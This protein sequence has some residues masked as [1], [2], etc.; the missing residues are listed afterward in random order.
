MILHVNRQSI[1]PGPAVHTIIAE[2]LPRAFE[3]EGFRELSRD[4][5][6]PHRNELVYGSQGP[7]PFF[8]NLNDMVQMS[9][10]RAVIV[11][12]NFKRQLSYALYKLRSP[13]ISVK[14][15]LQSLGNEVVLTAAEHSDLIDEIKNLLI[16]VRELGAI[17]RPLLEGFMAK[18]V[19]DKADPFALFVDPNQT[20]GKV[21]D[22][23]SDEWLLDH[24]QWWWFDTLHARRT[25]DFVT[26]LLDIARGEATGGDSETAQREQL[27]SYAIGYLS[28]MASDVVGHAY[29]NSIVG[30]PYRLNQAQRHTVQEKIMDIWAYDYY[31]DNADLPLDLKRLTEESQQAPHLPDR[32]YLDP[33]LIESGM[34]NNFLFTGGRLEPIQWEPDPELLF[35]MQPEKPITNSLRLPREISDNFAEAIGRVYDPDIFGEF[36]AAEAD[37]SYRY[38][39]RFIESA[40]SIFGPV[41]PSELPGDVI[42]SE[43][44]H[45][46]WDEFAEAA[47]DVVDAV[48]PDE[49]ATERTGSSSDCFR[50]EDLAEF[51]QN[52]LDC[53]G[54]AA[55]S[56]VNFFS[57]LFKSLVS[58]IRQAWEIV[59]TLFVTI[60]DEGISITV[61]IVNYGIAQA[62]ERLW[63]AHRTLLL[64]VTSIGFSYMYKDQLHQSQL[65]HFYDPTIPD[66]IGNTPRDLIV[67]PGT[68]T[69]GFPRYGL[70]M[71]PRFDTQVSD[72]LQGLESEGHL[73]VPDTE[74]EDPYTIPGPDIYGSA[75]PEVFISDPHAEMAAA[76][77]GDDPPLSEWIP[78]PEAH[79]QNPSPGG[80]RIRL[81]DFRASPDARG[82]YAKPVLGNAVDLTV[83]LFKQYLQYGNVPNL[84][85]SGDRAIGFPNWAS[86]NGCGVIDRHRWRSWHGD[87]VPWLNTPIDPI[88]VPDLHPDGVGDALY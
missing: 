43:E 88:F 30:G 15:S 78:R 62:Y 5:L 52:T 40:T 48:S 58:L 57:G 59:K 47:S 24:S 54:E 70:M 32:Y 82:E 21:K 36:T 75:T 87:H 74:I 7:D 77:G 18:N 71:G 66:A 27:L 4:A 12:M 50:G 39:Y 85:M 55:S 14:R 63:T 25:G 44:L 84:N 20:C 38:W 9:V 31:Y 8:F 2:H 53:L 29:V 76:L 81:E 51:F 23:R 33:E 69:S 45:E 49:A 65:R 13:I 35:Q 28:H 64:L 34:H 22:G 10:A 72:I 37:L 6:V 73:V 3:D 61:R 11:W 80:D 79:S 1:M 42:L 41:H 68:E 16:R 26:E 17:V 46:A 83:E 19:L 56:V 60:A 67:M 86:Q